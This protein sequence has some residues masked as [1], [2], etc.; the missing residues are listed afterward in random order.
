M[1]PPFKSPS[2]CRALFLVTIGETATLSGPRPWVRRF[3]VRAN[4]VL[5]AV[6]RVSS[7]TRRRVVHAETVGETHHYSSPNGEVFAIVS[8]YNGESFDEA[9]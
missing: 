7:L 9:L 1:R 5:W 4:T 6:G 2:I 8:P 3:K